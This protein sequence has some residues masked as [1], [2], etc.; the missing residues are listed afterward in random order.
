MPEY[1]AH[2]CN[3]GIKLTGTEEQI[4]KVNEQVNDKV[5]DKVTER[6]DEVL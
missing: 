1:F 6:K 3:N 5:T 2:S 4:V